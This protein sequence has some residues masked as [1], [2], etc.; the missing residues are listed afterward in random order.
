MEGEDG[1]LL[2]ELFDDLTDYPTAFGERGAADAV[3]TFL[4][5]PEGV[6]HDAKLLVGI[7]KNGGLIG[8]LDCILGYPTDRNWTVGM[9]AVAQRHR[10]QGVGRSV[11]GWLE[12]TAA[13]RGADRIRCVVRRTNTD[14]LDFL[15]RHDYRP[16]AEPAEDPAVFVLAK[17]VRWVDGA[18]GVT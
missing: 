18:P 7:W 6:G 15:T 2:Q 8:A 17:P 5:L 16:E 14:G 10:G 3:S 4:A 1:P 11:L 9:L 13:R 12:A